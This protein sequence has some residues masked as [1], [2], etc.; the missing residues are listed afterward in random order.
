MFSGQILRDRRISLTDMSCINT[1]SQKNNRSSV[2]THENI[3]EFDLG[4]F[5]QKYYFNQHSK[6]IFY[7]FFISEHFD[8][9]NIETAMPVLDIDA[10][11]NHIKAAKEAEMRVRN[12]TENT[13]Q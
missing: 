7:I 5:I 4:K 6:D 11:E 12:S 1:R 9:Y 8:V 10:I 13:L 3:D 2:R